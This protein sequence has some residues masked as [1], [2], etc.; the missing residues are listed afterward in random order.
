MPAIRMTNVMPAARM[1]MKVF[2]RSTFDRFAIVRNV[3]VDTL[4]TTISSAS[5]MKIVYF[6]SQR[7]IVMRPPSPWP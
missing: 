5:A 2:W 1:A 4:T 3:D 7:P 6:E